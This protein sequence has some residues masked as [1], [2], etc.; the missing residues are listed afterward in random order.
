MRGGTW[1][2]VNSIALVIGELPY[3]AGRKNGRIAKN[4]L[5]CRDVSPAANP[6]RFKLTT[7]AK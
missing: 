7:M 1:A 5:V 3:G 2:F 4:P 6:G